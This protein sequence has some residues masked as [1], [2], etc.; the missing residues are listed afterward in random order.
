MPA[1]QW[2]EVVKRVVGEV[3]RG[4]PFVSRMVKFV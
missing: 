3:V 1:A 4:S 2:V